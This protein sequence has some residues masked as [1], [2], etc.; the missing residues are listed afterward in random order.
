[1]KLKLH[2]T[3][4][5]WFFLQILQKIRFVDLRQNDPF[6]KKPIKVSSDWL[7]CLWLQP[8]GFSS[9]RLRSPGTERVTTMLC[10]SP[11]VQ[12][13]NLQSGS[14]HCRP[15]VEQTP[16]RLRS[17]F[18]KSFHLCLFWCPALKFLIGS[19]P[20][21]QTRTGPNSLSP[22]LPDLFESLLHSSW[23]F[24]IDVMNT[25]NFVFTVK[26]QGFCANHKWLFYFVK[27]EMYLSDPIKPELHFTANPC[28]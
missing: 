12:R 19:E 15:S 26:F 22:T 23:T 16:S 8:P 27:T 6:L 1:M 24:K 13:A 9:S 20:F 14:Q 21:L 18:Q 25:M 17:L 7:L 28:V 11:K 2:S 4:Y 5:K 10:S 3:F